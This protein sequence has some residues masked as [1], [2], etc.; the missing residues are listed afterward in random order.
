MAQDGEC[1][2]RRSKAQQDGR[3]ACG[4][5]A[6]VRRRVDGDERAGTADGGPGDERVSDHLGARCHD[7]ELG[8]GAERPARGDEVV[9]RR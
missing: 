4:P 2:A 8:D 9:Q 1:H 3:R 5:S 6:G 7:E